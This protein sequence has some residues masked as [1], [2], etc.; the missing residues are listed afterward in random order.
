MVQVSPQLLLS[1]CLFP[2]LLQLLPQPWRLVILLSFL[3]RCLRR[4]AQ[5]AWVSVLSI[6]SPPTLEPGPVLAE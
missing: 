1:I 6:V 4:A 2:S 5:P 3:R